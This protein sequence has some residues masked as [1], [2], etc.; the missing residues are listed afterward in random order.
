MPGHLLASM[1]MRPLRTALLRLAPVL[2]TLALL[3]CGGGGDNEA[4]QETPPDPVR[5][6]Q[7]AHSALIQPTDLPGEGWALHSND[8]FS[9]D[10][11]TLPEIDPCR[12]ARNLAI[13]ARKA[14]IGRAQRAM[15]QPIEGST[16]R[17]QVEVHVRI[18]DTRATAEGLLNRFRTAMSGDTYIRCLSEG[19]RLQFGPKT[20][21]RG[22]PTTTSAPHG[23]VSAGFDQDF[24]VNETQ[25]ALHTDEYAWTQSNAYVLVLVSGPR[26]ALTADLASAALTKSVAQVESAFKLP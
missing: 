20:S 16:L 9:N 18:Y 22:A 11:A 4:S 2:S 26:D 17:L 23:G 21:V 7:I 6:N 12:P 13:D 10:D 14:Q 19:F 24:L 3:A 15:Q 25:Y 1:A 8:N 5:A